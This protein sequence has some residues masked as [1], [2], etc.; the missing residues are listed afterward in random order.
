MNEIASI[1]QAF[2]EQGVKYLIAGGVAVVLHGYTRA[3]GDLDLLIE[4][5]SENIKQCIQ[6]LMDHNYQPRLPLDPFI[7]ADSNIRKNWVEEKGM[8]VFSFFHRL[9]PV[10]GIDIFAK[11]PLEK[12]PDFDNPTKRKLAEIQVNVCPL[13]DLILMKQK[14]NRSKDLQDIEA[15]KNILDKRK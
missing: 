15:L 9:K 1:L 13:E 7:F 14:A 6:I 12:T 10:F 3:T 11:Y 8:E 2:N 4:L 5:D